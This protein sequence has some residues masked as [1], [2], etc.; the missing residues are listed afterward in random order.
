MPVHTRAFSSLPTPRSHLTAPWLS[1]AGP[2]PP[3]RPPPR[4]QPLPH[5][6][7]QGLPSSLSHSAGLANTVGPKVMK[8]RP[9]HLPFLRGMG[10]RRGSGGEK[11]H[12]GKGQEN[13]S[14][15]MAR[16]G[17][18]HRL[19]LPA[20]PSRPHRQPADQ[21]VPARA[22]PFS[23]TELSLPPRTCTSSATCALREPLIC[24]VF[25][26]PPPS[27]LLATGILISSSLSY[28]ENIPSSASR[29]LPAP[30]RPTFLHSQSS[31]S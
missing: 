29:P 7:S 20:L 1:G 6:P 16:L 17:L 30:G 13:G 8:Q 9:F 22:C 15:V 31:Y 19:W 28:P 18:L 10:G 24:S 27:R 26:P 2:A 14:T 5:R 11:G 21:Q 3:T 25:S 4:F 12:Q 23:V